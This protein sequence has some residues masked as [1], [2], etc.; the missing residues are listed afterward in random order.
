MVLGDMRSELFDRSYLNMADEKSTLPKF[1][2][3]F[4]ILI[5]RKEKSILHE[6]IYKIHSKLPHDTI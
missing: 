6:K 1:V 2:A 4:V 5:K 3:I